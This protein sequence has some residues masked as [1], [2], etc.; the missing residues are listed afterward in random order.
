MDAEGQ[1]VVLDHSSDLA[2]WDLRGLSCTILCAGNVK[3]WLLRPW[4]S[5]EPWQGPSSMPVVSD[6]QLP[7]TAAKLP[8]QWFSSL[9]GR[10]LVD[11]KFENHQ[12]QQR[13]TEFV[14]LEGHKNHQWSIYQSVADWLVRIDFGSLP[15][16]DALWGCFSKCI[17]D[18][19][20]E[21]QNFN[22]DQI[23]KSCEILE[24]KTGD[25]LDSIWTW[26]LFLT[27][28]DIWLIA[29]FGLQKLV[30]YCCVFG[31]PKTFEICG[32]QVSPCHGQIN[33]T[34]SFQSKRTHGFPL[35]TACQ[36]QS[37]GPI[38]K[39]IQAGRIYIFGTANSFC[40]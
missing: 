16:K 32:N 5:D 3:S 21:I 29:K 7:G 17:L 9:H 31:T 39:L 27:A 8:K 18:L 37:W 40:P 20:S 11:E 1:D 4:G 35:S 26:G 13:N 23:H 33:W 14:I 6:R 15:I 24:R 28:G 2:H 12:Y 19:K 38:P 36:D 22:E 30:Q 34:I 10:A 25:C